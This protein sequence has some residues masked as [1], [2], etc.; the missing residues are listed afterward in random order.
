MTVMVAVTD[1]PEGTAALHAAVTESQR[2][3][4][5]LVVV[6]L[7]LRPIDLSGIPADVP[8]RVVERNGRGDRDP[9][10]AVLDEIAAH[11]VARLVIGVRH[12]TPAGKALLGSISQR[13][14]LES[15]VPVLAVK[16]GRDGSE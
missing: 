15:P 3:D 1:R 10:T 6:N 11:D 16:L 4:T 7:A 8:L 13:L 2:F 14:L 9:V 5:D 12:R